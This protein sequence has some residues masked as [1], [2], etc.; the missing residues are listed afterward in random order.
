MSQNPDAQEAV[1]IAEMVTD[2][3][4]RCL[5]DLAP[6]ENT[7]GLQIRAVQPRQCP[8]F[9]QLLQMVAIQRTNQV[10]ESP[11]PLRDLQVTQTVFRQ[12]VIQEE[13][14]RHFAHKAAERPLI[15]RVTKMEDL[16][17]TRDPH[18][19][20]TP[21]TNHV[22]RFLRRGKHVVI[23]VYQEDNVPLKSFARVECYEVYDGPLSVSLLFTRYSNI[24]KTA[25][26]PVL[27]HFLFHAIQV[28][29]CSG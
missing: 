26:H 1:E 20:Q 3:P 24:A 15:P 8:L 9:A 22:L 4:R 16:P 6:S 21:L 14:R 5:P 29:I 19:K 12:A 10:L 27:Y 17:C 23:A 2:R 18:I 11:F 28:A 25:A 13:L 7:L